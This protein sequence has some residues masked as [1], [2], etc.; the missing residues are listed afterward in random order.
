[1]KTRLQL[2]FEHL[3]RITTRRIVSW[4]ALANQIREEYHNRVAEADRIV[5]F[6]TQRDINRRQTADAQTLRRLE[7]NQKEGIIDLEESI[8]AAL[9][10]LNYPDYDE[11]L[12]ESAARFGMLPA[13]IPNRD[14]GGAMHDFSRLTKEFSQLMAAVAEPLANNEFD[15]NDLPHL[16]E[17]LNEITD[18][19]G[20]LATI[21]SAVT[22]VM[23]RN[24]VHAIRR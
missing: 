3:N 23:M 4:P 13:A 20:C 21:R 12:R 22:E 14:V 19:E 7:H 5:K 17:V 9:K 24:N 6:S 8:F 16:P 1:M 11:L 18:M 2:I 10:A 15:D